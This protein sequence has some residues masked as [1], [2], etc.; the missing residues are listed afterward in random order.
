M[1]RDGILLLGAVILGLF[2][3]LLRDLSR[4]L[5]LALGCAVSGFSAPYGRP[6]AALRR[7]ALG[8]GRGEGRLFLWD[9]LSLALMGVSFRL[10]LFFLGDGSFRLFALLGAAL[11]L[12]LWCATFGRLW[13]TWVVPLAFAL[14]LFVGGLVFV[15]TYPLR[16]AAMLLL[17]LW[18]AHRLSTYRRRA[19]FA[20]HPPSK[21]IG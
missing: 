8:R 17:R 20:I 3:G 6:P 13:R 21:K 15:L 12:F 11:G 7:L 1:E 14:R 18:D 19:L 2:W 4:L 10:L 5:R 9:A 16:L